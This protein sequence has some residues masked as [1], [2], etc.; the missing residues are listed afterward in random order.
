MKKF[1]IL[2]T[3]IVL[4]TGCAASGPHYSHEVPAKD[5]ALIYVYREWRLANGGG[6]PTIALNGRKMDDLKNG[7]FLQFRVAPGRHKVEQL[8]SI[9]DWIFEAEP[10]VVN[11]DAGEVYYVQLETDA[12][13]SFNGVEMK[14]RSTLSFEEV[15]ASVALPKLKNLKAVH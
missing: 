1:L 6:S 2:L 5:E 13:M 9:W 11:A 4:L 14:K 15:P 8:T 3:S 7:S 12:T 10:V